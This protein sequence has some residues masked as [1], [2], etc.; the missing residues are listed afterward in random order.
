SRPHCPSHAVGIEF[1]YPDNGQRHFALD[2]RI[3]SRILRVAGCDALVVTHDQLL[4]EQWSAN[5]G[6]LQFFRSARLS[7]A[8]QFRRKILLD[9]DLVSHIRREEVPLHPFE[10]VAIS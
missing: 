2:Y 6:S 9:D 7:A 1:G 8:K 4:P 5:F 10:A 3:R